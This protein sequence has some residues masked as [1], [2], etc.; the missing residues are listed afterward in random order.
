MDIDIPRTS[1]ELKA[2]K[3]I[4]RRK[5]VEHIERQFVM[6]ALRRNDW[7]VTRAA[8]ETDMQRTNF[9]ALMHKYDIH[10]RNTTGGS[11]V[12]EAS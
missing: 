12:S 2:I 7:N 3:K 10:A 8:G 11:G 4:A 6:E 9:Q 1:E 5:S